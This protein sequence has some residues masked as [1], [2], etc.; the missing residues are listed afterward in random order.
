MRHRTRIIVIASVVALAL[1]G[2]VMAAIFG[3][4]QYYKP[5]KNIA[6]TKADLVIDA[7]TLYHA[8]ETDEQKANATYTGKILEVTG[9]VAEVAVNQGGE[10]TVIL[11]ESDAM[12][13][14]FCTM[15]PED[16]DDAKAFAAGKKVTV[17]GTCDGYNG[18][19]MMPGDVV[20]TRCS[21]V[22]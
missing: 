2:I 15:R 17:K 9:S 3:L 8:F 5:A 21:I 12:N 16:S 4:T 13:G 20:M 10:V 1:F 22:K 14:V 18:M 11:R 7:N 19:E 6:D